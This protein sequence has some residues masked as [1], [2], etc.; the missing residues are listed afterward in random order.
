MRAML[1]NFNIQMDDQNFMR[2][3][4]RMD[5][6]QSGTVNYREFLDFF[7]VAI[8]GAGTKSAACTLQRTLGDQLTTG[9]G[10]L[11]RPTGLVNKQQCIALLEAK[12]EAAFVDVGRAFRSFDLDHSG[13]I[14]KHEFRRLL[15]RFCLHLSDDDF[16]EMYRQF[17]V[18]DV[19]SIA[20]DE[21]VAYFGKVVAPK[22]EGGVGITL[23]A[24]N[25]ND[26]A[27]ELDALYTDPPPVGFRKGL[28]KP[29]KPKPIPAVSIRPSSARPAVMERQSVTVDSR[30]A[31]MMIRFMVQRELPRLREVWK[32]YDGDG[33]SIIRTRKLRE[34][35]AGLGL[36]MNETEYS[37]LLS[38]M[39][40]K[41][42]SVSFKKF[43]ENF[44]GTRFDSSVVTSIRQRMV[45]QAAPAR[46]AEER[47]VRVMSKEEEHCRRVLQS[48]ILSERSVLGAFKAWDR[49]KSGLMSKHEFKSML[50]KFGIQ[51]EPAAMKALF[52]K[53]DTD[54]SG[55]IDLKEFIAYFDRDS[56][57]VHASTPKPVTPVSSR[58]T[59]AEIKCEKF[60]SQQRT[61]NSKAVDMLR[62]RLSSH[63]TKDSTMVIRACGAVDKHRTGYIGLPEMRVIADTY[64]FAVTPQ[65]FDLVME[66]YTS[67]MENGRV[68]VE[69]KRFLLDFTKRTHS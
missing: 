23:Q 9:S 36:A 25:C 33:S 26:Q 46:A 2:L 20:Y 63:L 1:L 45:K 3:M 67:K 17:D 41:V 5:P 65:Q 66:P 18:E 56:H 51:M 52:D 13:A 24:A 55:S 21:F 39:G 43:V 47:L 6:D 37:K 7:G 31:K 10:Q 68:K 8:T 29:K 12:L 16:D 69:Y 59:R 61:M 32:M 54:H 22:E 14:S 28:F 19:G 50:T 64:L 58:T 15:A 49:D 40:L 27:A 38:E 48:R 30:E 11:L 53:F 62:A 35:L 57:A 34:L 42:T 60:R 44:D 4:H